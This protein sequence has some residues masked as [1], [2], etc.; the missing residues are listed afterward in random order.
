MLFTHRG[1]SGPAIL[2][3]SSYWKKPEPIRIDWSP[4]QQLL[5]PLRAPN[6]PRD[7]AALKTALRAHLPVRLADGLVGRLLEGRCAAELYESRAR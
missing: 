7:L 3:I 4:G 5:A 6:A 2:Q 1:L